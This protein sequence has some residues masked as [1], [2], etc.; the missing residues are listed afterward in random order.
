MTDETTQND[1]SCPNCGAPMDDN[2][3]YFDKY[4]ICGS[5]CNY[6]AGLRSKIQNMEHEW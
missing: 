1:E 4:G 3:F 2:G 6:A 5:M